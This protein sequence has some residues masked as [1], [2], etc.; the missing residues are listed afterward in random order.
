MWPP[1]CKPGMRLVIFDVF[2]SSDMISCD[3][4]MLNVSNAIQAYPD[5]SKHLFSSQS[6]RE[7]MLG[8]VQKVLFILI[9]TEIIE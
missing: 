4:N 7:P 8:S 3:H 6:R 5:A 9:V 2:A 1:M